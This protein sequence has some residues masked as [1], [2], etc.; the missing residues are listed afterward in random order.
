MSAP[1]EVSTPFRR[2]SSV[3]SKSITLYEPDVRFH[4]VHRKVQKFIERVAGEKC[5]GD[6]SVKINMTI[7]QEHN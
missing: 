5:E 7:Y 1:T 2:G 4:P 3:A 6:E